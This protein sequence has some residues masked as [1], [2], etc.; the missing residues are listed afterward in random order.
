MYILSKKLKAP[1]LGAAFLLFKAITFS[2][3]T[4]MRGWITVTYANAT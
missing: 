1:I 3:G 2:I 4:A